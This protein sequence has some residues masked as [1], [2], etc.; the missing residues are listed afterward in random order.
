MIDVLRIPLKPLNST[1]VESYDAVALVDTQ[2][3]TGNNSM[4]K[5]KTPVIVFDHH[6]LRKAT[7]GVPFSDIREDY[8]ATATILYEY[9]EPAGIHPDRRLASA[10]FH[11][12]RSETQNLGREAGKPDARVFLEC[13]PLVDNEALSRIEHA[14]LQRNYFL[15]MGQAIEGTSIYSEIAVTLLGPVPTPD[16]VA[17]FA[18]LIIRLEGIEWALCIGRYRSDLLLSIRTNSRRHNA[19]RMI[20]AIVGSQGTAGGHDMIAGGKIAGAAVTQVRARRTE[21]ML[22]RRLLR[23]LGA[24]G[25]RPTGL[26][27]SLR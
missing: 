15:M 14:R 25:I 21:E 19:G 18:D 10:I 7:R 20:R 22:R 8:G 1:D 23:E 4:P 6:P 12:I 16:M 13:F 26:T 3:A 17:Q 2:P 11:A 9:L 27:R 5:H 24:S